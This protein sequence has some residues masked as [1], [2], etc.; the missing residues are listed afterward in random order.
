[1]SKGREPLRLDVRTTYKLFID[2]EFVRSESDRTEVVAG[3]D[4]VRV[5]RASR[6]DLRAALASATRAFGVWSGLTPLARG[7]GLYRLAEALDGRRAHL[8]E[9]LR[10]NPKT[11]EPEAAREADAAIDRTL[12]Y[13]GWCDKY[14]YALSGVVPVSGPFATA[15]HPEPIGV[16]AA[17][18]PDEPSLLG[19]VST[20]VP[21]LVAGNSV[22]VL[23]SETDPRTAVAFAECVG[24]A[25]LPRG[26]LNVLTGRRIELAPLF[27]KDPGVAAL[28][29][30]GLDAPFAAEL[31]RMAADDLKRCELHPA[32]SSAEWFSN[33]SLDLV[34][35]AAFTTQKTVWQPARV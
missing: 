9:R 3:D 27:A 11:D 5:A 23:A 29:A 17:L 6:D 30:F 31:A 10:A 16:V 28:H 34:R 15:T 14:A 24:A 21:A 7:E 18:A 20:V 33:E 19:L 13:A 1:M 35:V 8:I 2:G 12:W 26:T 32:P 25:G 4:T 22:V